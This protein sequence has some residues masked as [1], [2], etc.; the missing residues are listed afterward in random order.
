MKKISIV[1]LAVIV[2]TM[3]LAVP[4]H[5]AG[6][7]IGLTPSKKIVTVG[8]TF[9]VGVEVNNLNAG[10]EGIMGFIGELQY[11]NNILET[12]TTDDITGSNGWSVS[13]NN[14]SNK[15]LA[16]SNKYITDDGE[17]AKI[18]FKVKADATLGDT[19]IKIVNA[20]VSSG[21][22]GDISGIDKELKISVKNIDSD[23]Y[24]IEDNVIKG[25][26]A[27]STATDIKNNIKTNATVEVLDK[28]GQAL[29]DNAVIGTGSIIKVDGKDSYTVIVK[30]DLSG[31]GQVTILD[32]AKVK[33]HLI[34][35]VKLTDAYLTAAD[36][37][38]DGEVG[39]TDMVLIIKH[40]I[41]LETLK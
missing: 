20:K 1:L 8:S 16:S 37:N 4:V 23:K 38:N 36:I 28:D 21:S 27:G 30:G 32:L 11:N 7:A 41:G 39:L 12:V 9:T 18:T 31:D 33:Y 6:F 29:A 3:T 17:V 35:E 13:F 10:A 19:S 14:Q 40:V 22:S 15:I 34:E 2:L 5:A 25:V 24:E 26:A